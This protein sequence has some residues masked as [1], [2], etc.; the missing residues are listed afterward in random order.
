MIT[1]NPVQHVRGLEV[2]TPFQP[3]KKKAAQTEKSTTLLRS[4]REVSS[5]GKPLPP[6]LEDKQEDT[7]NH[8]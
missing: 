7:E 4:T 6:K 2:T 8:K 5:Q 3:K 1:G